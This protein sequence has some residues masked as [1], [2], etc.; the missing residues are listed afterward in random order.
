M[1]EMAKGIKF[2]TGLL[3]ADINKLEGCIKQD[4]EAADE[5]YQRGYEAGFAEGRKQA[6]EHDG[7]GGCAYESRDMDEEPCI[8]CQGRYLDQY[9]RADGEIRVGD[10][11]A[12]FD[13]SD[14]AACVLY[15][16]HDGT[17]CMVLKNDGFVSW[18]TKAAISKTGR[19]FDEVE[20]LLEAMRK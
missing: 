15:D 19:H 9:R 10:E 17:Q 11:V 13:N 5:A 3:R 20:K 14:R 6:E 7:C 12:P 4:G 18:W 8:I 1:Q 2:E 16:N